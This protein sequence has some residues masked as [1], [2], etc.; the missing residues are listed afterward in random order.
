MFLCSKSC[1]FLFVALILPWFHRYLDVFFFLLV[2]IVLHL[3]CGLHK[4]YFP[5]NCLFL[6]ITTQNF[7]FWSLHFLNLLFPYLKSCMYLLKFHSSWHNTSGSLSLRQ[8]FISSLADRTP[9]TACIFFFFSVVTIDQIF[10]SR[11]NTFSV[12]GRILYSTIFSILIIFLL[13]PKKLLSFPF[14]F[15]CVS[16]IPYYL[17]SHISWRFLLFY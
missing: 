12:F 9:S 3:P 17:K 15:T 2:F 11:S 7:L 13:F 1:L 10:F 5:S 6:I 8:C 4:I 16:P 14:S